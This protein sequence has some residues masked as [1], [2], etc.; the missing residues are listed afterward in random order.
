MLHLKWHFRN[1]ERDISTNPFNT[2]STFKKAEYHLGDT[3]TYEE[4]LNDAKPLM[5]II[6]NTLEN[7][8]KKEDVCTDTLID[9]DTEFLIKDA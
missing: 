6:I 8:C 3:N 5:N 2:K 9:T 1:D 4:V 7:I